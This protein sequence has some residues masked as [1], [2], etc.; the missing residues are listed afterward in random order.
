MR[1]SRVV[2][3]HRADLLTTA[4]LLEGDEAAAEHRVHRALARLPA[5]ADRTAALRALL[6]TRPARSAF[7]EE[8]AA[9]WWASPAELAAA[10]RTA[11]TLAGLDDDDR[12]A[13]VLADHEG[14][15]PAGLVPGPIAERLDRARS[16]L[17]GDPRGELARLAGVRRPSQRTEGEAVAAVRAVRR[18]RRRRPQVA[19][20]VLALL[21]VLV[22]AAVGRFDDAPAVRAAPAGPLDGPVRGSLAGDTGFLDAVRDVWTGP[23][24]PLDRRVVLA[25]DLLDQRWVLVVGSTAGGLLGQWSTGPAGAAPGQLT[26][27][28]RPVVLRADRP[29]ALLDG[30]ALVVVVGRDQGVRVSPGQTVGPAGSVQRVY[31]PQPVDDGVAAV[32][33]AAP[34][35]SG[36]AVRVQVAQA[37]ES[38]ATTLTDVPVTLSDR[39]VTS[40]PL[41]A[42]TAVRPTGTPDPD[43]VATA[44]LSVTVPTGLDPSTLAPQLLW[45]GPLPAPIDQAGEDRVVQGVVLAVP[46]P[47][48]AV[49]VSTAAA[50]RREDGTLQQV[51]CGMQA[52]P[53]G[54]DPAALV[55]AARCTV[56]DRDTGAAVS[57][58]L[59]V[60][61]PGTA[62]VQLVGG[63][64]VDL[65]LTDGM[66]LLVDDGR[67]RTV[68]QLADRTRQAVTAAGPGDLFEE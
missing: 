11:A 20:S 60:A 46:V 12:T 25:G 3:A 29:A 7:T 5:D 51:G 27:A 49:V 61:P 4:F 66:G 55:V 2:A 40:P 68:V 10:R 39:S 45:A 59:V 57:T 64:P 9:P 21:A 16:A 24:A 13:L 32:R 58:V 54:T 22:P 6:R 26:P 31:T 41:P 67:T 34:D 52:L 28:N 19:L 43:A 63:E 42:V 17:D 15:D 36:R 62:A 14:T 56:A 1:E 53:A 47:G 50:G 37:G 65:T 38:H 33:V 30:T 23:D 18:A 44:L 48:S 8:R 35:T